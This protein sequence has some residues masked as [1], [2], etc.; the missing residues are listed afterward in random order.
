MLLLLGFFVFKLCSKTYFSLGTSIKIAA[1]SVLYEVILNSDLMPFG[2]TLWNKHYLPSLLSVSHA[3]FPLPCHWEALWYL[4]T[5]GSNGRHLVH[6]IGAYQMLGSEVIQL[7]SNFPGKLSQPAWRGDRCFLPRLSE[8]R[9][10][11][12]GVGSHYARGGWS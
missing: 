5:W 1:A 10:F 3:P 7:A 8:I 2:S 12:W 11:L 9:L 6:H 4:W